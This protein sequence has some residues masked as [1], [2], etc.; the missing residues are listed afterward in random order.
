MAI[1]NTPQLSMRVERAAYSRLAWAFAISLTLHLVVYGGYY[2]GKKFGWWQNWRWPAW[3][4]TPK[5]LSELLK[6]KESPPPPQLSPELPLIFVDV[7]PATATPEPP[8]DTPYYSSKNSKAANL[9]PDQDA[10]T[11]KIDGKQQDMVK[12]EDVPHAKVFPLQP[13]LPAETA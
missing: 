1:A 7:N 12:T 5:M 2:A 8:K 9:E 4:Q 3:M 10:N 13:A 11:P 6:K